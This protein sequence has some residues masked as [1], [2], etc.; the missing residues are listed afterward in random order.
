MTSPG[1]SSLGVRAARSTAQ[2]LVVMALALFAAAGTLRYWQAWIYLGLQATSMT[3]TNAYLLHRAPDLLRRRLA[4]E[5][6]G[7]SERLHRL[8]FALLRPLGLA[9]LV[10]AGL[11]RRFG[12][13]DVPAPIVAGATLALAAG[14]L[15]I[16][17]VFRENAHA[18]SIIEVDAQQTV[19]STG[20]YRLVRHPMYAGVLLGAAATPLALGSLRA[21]IFFPLSCALFVVRLLAEERFLA[22]ELP[23]YTAYMSKTR[24]RLVPGLW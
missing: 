21:E 10:V 2:V 19:V 16:F 15:V 8:F 22:D 9:T 5:E 1:A 12:W 14:I 3:A 17:L 24:R 11:D 23:G 20:P 7:E 13:S 6:Q 4:A 18:S